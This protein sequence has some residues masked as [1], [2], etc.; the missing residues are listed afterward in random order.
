[1]TQD[2]FIIRPALETDYPVMDQV[3]T[4]SV[5]ELCVGV[6]TPE[7]IEEW[8]G[9]PRPERYARGREKG[10]SYYVLMSGDKMY[11][12]CGIG[13]KRLMIEAVFVHPDMAGK[14]IGGHLLRHLFSVATQAGINKLLVESSLNAVGFYSKHGFV[15]YGRSKMA[16]T[17]GKKIDGVLMGGEG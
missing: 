11:G 16:L 6:Y 12:Y 2:K 13:L 9:K 7:L 17:T 8:V 14:G 4:A 10:A 5:R 15:E 1:M 3:Q